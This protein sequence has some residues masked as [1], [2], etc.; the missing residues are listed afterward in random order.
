MLPM[1]VHRPAR[2]TVRARRARTG[3]PADGPL[4]LPRAVCALT[5]AAALGGC[6]ASR[7]AAAVR[8]VAEPPT[9]ARYAPADALDS[10]AGRSLSA[11]AAEPVAEA[12][13]PAAEGIVQVA[14]LDE[15]VP[16]A[17]G[18][19][20]SSE[21]VTPLAPVDPAS[22]WSLPALEA[23]AL[24][25]NPA[26][27]QA[28]AAVAKARG[29]RQQV[30]ALP[31]P[32]MG[33]DG[34]QLFDRGTDQHVLFVEQ[35]LVLGDKLA[36]NRAVLSQEVQ[37]LL[38]EVEAQRYRVLTDVRQRYYEA[39]AA[40]RRLQLADE[41]REIAGNG[42]E[43]ARA[44][45]AAKEGA[46]PEL[47]QAEIQLQQV[48]I[49]SR[50][51]EAAFRGAW[52]QLT[53]VAGVSAAAPGVLA[54]ELPTSGVLIDLAAAKSLAAS[55]SPELQA[56]RSRVSRARENVHRQQVQATPNL[57]LMVAGGVDNGTNSGMMNAQVGLPVPLF[58][59]NDG[60]IA[61]AHA[62]LQRACQELRRMELA[63]ESR[64]ARGTQEYE[65]AAAAVE[66]YLQAILP[67]AEET[68]KLTEQAY[69]AGETEFLQVLVARRTYFDAHLE[70]VAARA[71]LAQAQA[72]LA[73]LALSGGLEATRDTE[74]DAGLRDQA[75]SGQ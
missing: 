43:V 10:Q 64:M 28:S 19:L 4:N 33:Y 9:F 14:A 50:Q 42:V 1:V 75:L 32:K 55:T 3:S 45:L 58:N 73:G 60:N 27:R 51:A 41:F 21:L 52:N 25:H 44:R 31:N 61:A 71:S 26:I 57:S 54:G 11:R 67:R 34:T 72:Y 66:L 39:L 2:V 68:L 62:E 13:A 59:R 16:L 65:S 8:S 22:H 38:W 46:L 69:A 29:Y 24:E 5:L 47:L 36:R 70:A 7:D 48:E 12:R 6:A 56:A 40:Q 23:L 35:D 37:V 53:A 30:G 49:Q 63:I 17:P 20:G 74:F 18:G 15:G